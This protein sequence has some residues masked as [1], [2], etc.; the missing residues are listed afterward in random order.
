VPVEQVD[1]GRSEPV[2]AALDRCLD[3]RAGKA[4]TG[5]AV[6]R[7]CT[8]LGRDGEFIAVPTL[9]E[10]TVEQQFALVTGASG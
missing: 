6:N 10:P 2:Q 1:V 5:A 4:F 3:R 8:D 9:G 7:A